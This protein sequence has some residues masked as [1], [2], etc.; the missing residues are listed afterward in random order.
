M[1]VARNLPPSPLPQTV[2]ATT[3]TAGRGRF[4]RRWVSPP[5]GGLYL[6]VRIPWNRPLAQ[7]PLV[8]IGAALA[9]ARVARQVGCV[10]IVLKW[11]NDLILGGCKAAGILAE[12]VQGEP[13]HLL[14][15]V[16]INVRIPGSALASVGQPA[17]SLSDAC[18]D[19]LDP[20]SVLSSFLD[21]WSQIDHILEGQGFVALA[22]EFRSQSDL[23]G[24]CF[25]L[26]SGVARTEV[27][28]RDIKDDGSLEVEIL[29]S[30]EIR[31]IFGGELLNLGSP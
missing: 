21:H 26:S 30:G 18:G 29:G 1:E 6:T 24:R 13:S 22:Q 19:P 23:S 27:R 25:L 17:I 10:D 5:E 7:A 31:C 16:G 3:Q 12:M 9:L 20:E 2:L 4:D 11:P 28:V 14:V 15:G 8:S